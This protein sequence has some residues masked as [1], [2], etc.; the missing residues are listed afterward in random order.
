M[1]TGHLLAPAKT[2]NWV[3]RPVFNFIDT[4]CIFYWPSYRHLFHRKIK[5][6]IYIHYKSNDRWQI[7]KV[8]FIA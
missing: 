5:T 2:I 8:D 6:E 1:Q 7:V 4:A 3:R